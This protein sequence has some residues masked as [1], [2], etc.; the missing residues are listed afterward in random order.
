[1][2]SLFS[3][4]VL[5]Q[6]IKAPIYLLNPTV[7]QSDT[8]SLPRFSV[9]HYL[10][11][12][13]DNHF[14]TRDL[15]YFRDI[16]T[17]KKIP[18]YTVM[19]LDTTAETSSISNKYAA[20]EVRKWHQ[21]NLKSFKAVNLIELPNKDTAVVAVYN[22]NLLKDLYRYKTSP[23]SNYHRF[24][25]ITS[26]Y[27][28][29]VKKGI[30]ADKE[31]VHFVVCTLPNN[32][33][34]YNI[35]NVILKFPEAKYARVIS[36]QQLLKI[37]DLYRWLTNSYRDSSTMK[38]ITDEDSRRIVIEFKYK[39][40]S[41]FLPL[42]TIR[43]ICIESKLEAD[44]KVPESKVQRLYVLMLLK[45]QEKVNTIL[46]AE[47]KETA[48]D[49]M[50]SEEDDLLTEGGDNDNDINE[51]PAAN[52][53]FVNQ[54]A[55]NGS[56][57]PTDDHSVGISGATTFNK[58]AA[59]DA[60]NAAIETD[61]AELDFT[62]LLDTKLDEFDA[63]MEETNRIYEES[64]LNLEKEPVE[65]VEGNI[66]IIP[67]Y[68]EENK[69]S[70]LK[71]KTIEDVF[72]KHIDE[73]VRFKTLTAAEIRSLKK[74]KENRASLKS[75][76]SKTELLDTHKVLTDADTTIAEEKIKLDIDN[77][78]IDDKLKRNI[79]GAF[80]SQYLKSVLKKD[81]VACVS[82][83]EDS[84]I[85]IKDY[86]VEVDRSAMGNYEVHRLTISPLD[87]KDSTIYFRLPVIDEEGSYYAAGIKYKMRK[88]RAD[89]PIRKIGESRVALT[90]NYGKLFI[91][92]TERKANDPYSY[93]ISTLQNDYLED[94]TFVTK[95]LPSSRKI[96][97]KT[98][99]PNIYSYLS[100]N[101]S[102][103]HTAKVTLL[104]DT[105][106]AT[107]HLDSKVITDIENKKLF[108]C[109]HLP[110]KHI[111]VV[112][113]N[114]MFYDYSANMTPIGDI[115]ELLGLDSTKIPKAFSAIKILGDNIPL[116]VCL[117]YYVGLS[118]L[119]ALTNSKVRT[120]EPGT[121]YKAKYNEIILKFNDAKLVIEP[122]GKDAELLFN[123]FLYY[124]DFIKQY[125]VTEF[126][127]KEIYLNLFE[128]RDA[129][130]MHI[131]ELN[132]LEELFLDPI[133]ID[134]LK[135]IN[136]PTDYLRLLLRANELLK[137]FVY[138]DVNDPLYSRIRGH[139]RVPGLMYKALSESIRDYRF[140]NS[141]KGKIE[142]DP[143]K[144]WNYVTQ[145]NTVKIVEDL[146]PVLN[147]KEDE[148]V[149]LSGADGFG[150]DAIPLMLRSYHENDMGLISEATVDSSDAGINTFLT[151]YA[152]L[153]SV[154]GL[155][156]EGFS[157]VEKSNAKMFSTS[158]MLAP[159]SEA[160][161][162]KRINFISIQNGHT[163]Y[164]PGYIQPIIRTTCEYI[165]PYKVGKLY[166]STAKE[167]GVIVSKTEK[168]ITIKYQSGKIEALPIGAKYGRME[169]SIYPHSLVTPLKAGD[170]VKKDAYI[171]YNEN[172]FE[173][174]W[175]NS[176]RLIMKFGKNVTVAFMMNNEV[177]E[178]SSAIS[179][180]LSKEMST[181]I[182]KEKVFVIEFSK[183][184]INIV[185]EG[186]AVTP[187]TVLFTAVDENTDYNNLS[188][189]S[190]EMLQSLAAL[191][192]KAKV[193]GTVVRY[194][195]KYNGDVSDMSP[196][197]KKL[198][199]RLDKE[200]REETVGTEYEVADNTVNT[201]Y[202]S[203]GKNLSIDTLELKVFI[204]V[205]LNQGC[206]D[207]G[208]IATQMK[209][210]TSDVY[211]Q[212]ITTTSGVKIDALF[213]FNGI[214][215]RVVNSPIL[216]GT[217]NRLVKHVSKQV[218]DIY[219]GS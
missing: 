131:K 170:K 49:M 32:I 187:S 31:S 27:W 191:S 86:T 163:I 26:T 215:G 175:L 213:S 200:T 20:M 181:T 64:I 33:P 40:Y 119:V 17:N 69:A 128:F 76:Y 132:L 160:D 171:T 120:L 19:D 104:L 197:I 148:T 216:M 123:G 87:A 124:K 161:D 162:G 92:R 138:P 205:N 149:T 157:E 158:A 194:E 94:Q 199:N 150:K 70:L 16:P 22:Y 136:E 164:S 45:M 5:R 99:M 93:I 155:V 66:N 206:G 207:K 111:V 72:S 53:G 109:G 141:R 85:I 189:S 142:L 210:I 62:R 202:R 6:A 25:N 186:T 140:K 80:D 9:L 144:V 156:E 127:R 203:E 183:N 43:S 30:S 179:A 112:D 2:L 190:I 165:I 126:G 3:Q 154:R 81:I 48:I 130:L 146:N 59:I 54:A 152:K 198:I 176:K 56:L 83:L 24:R 139:D 79:I 21:S 101:F 177:F 82:K 116:G 147:L 65:I 208:V 37:I 23:I 51:E 212:S 105:D 89:L 57:K 114:D 13:Q 1:M 166:C 74:I 14:P 219:F 71:N 61:I 50:P 135:S 169:G 8:A 88:Q 39:G 122:S 90:S 73:A 125:S 193:N 195:V 7:L 115:V 110:N 196:T 113:Y 35:L 46:N 60:A 84:G 15:S 28:N 18:I 129:G 98:K 77:A 41:A 67:D 121:R 95:I 47:I 12:R 106:S 103:V 107:N 52:S 38:D 151:P 182:V 184:L 192:P 58:A 78:F 159:A 217:T 91:Y 214:L 168:L 11:I 188:E 167:D 211:T 100:R 108:F 55:G 172:F 134:V 36:D 185:P 209:T 137:D 29:Y 133:T 4:F 145:D 201:E 97:H 42:S 218:A 75:P 34:N 180:D 117:G 174:D 68:S 44:T 102:E 153:K 204:S 143:Y 10:D 178:D 96:S 118:N 63:D 173:P